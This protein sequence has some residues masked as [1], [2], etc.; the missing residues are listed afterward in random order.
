MADRDKQLAELLKKGEKDWNARSAAHTELLNLI[1]NVPEDAPEE[2]RRE[3]L[4]MIN[5]KIRSEPVDK[6][7]KSLENHTR[8]TFGN[9][10]QSRVLL[11]I[12]NSHIDAYKKK[13][14]EAID[15]GAPPDD[16]EMAIGGKKRRGKKTK[17]TKK[18]RRYTRR[19]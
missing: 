12:A 13:L 9:D 16:T 2:K 15:K 6:K 1:E 10:Y 3:L 18:S 4:G 11:V 5:D 19:R 17:K 14:K 7:L 8:K